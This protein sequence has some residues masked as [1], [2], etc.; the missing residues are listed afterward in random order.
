MKRKLISGVAS[1]VLILVMAAGALFAKADKTATWQVNTRY[2]QTGY[3]IC[4]NTTEFPIATELAGGVLEI[5]C[6]Q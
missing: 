4:D 3:V 6:P 5:T 1:V 2:G